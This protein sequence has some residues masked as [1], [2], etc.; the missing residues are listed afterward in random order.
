MSSSR[1]VYLAHVRHS[2]NSTVVLA[3][4]SK[5]HYQHAYNW[6]AD[7]ADSFGVKVTTGDGKVAA[8]VLHPTEVGRCWFLERHEVQ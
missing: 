8:M 5:S 7:I 4:Y 2:D 6:L 3:V 1:T